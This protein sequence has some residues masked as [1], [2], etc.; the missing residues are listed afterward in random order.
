[1]RTRIVSFVL[2][3]VLA[4]S[5]VLSVAAQ[6]PTGARSLPASPFPGDGAVGS[7]PPKTGGLKPSAPTAT[8]L[9]GAADWLLTQQDAAGWFPW[10][11]GTGVTDNTQ[12]TTARGLLKAYLLTGTTGYRAAAV[13]NGDYLVPNYPRHFTDLDPRIV[14]HDALFL[15]EL[16][17][18]TG[19]AKYANFLQDY[20]WDKLTAGTY[21]EANNQDAA[22]WAA[23]VLSGRSGIV[24]LSPWD[25]SAPAIAAHIAGESAIRDAI[26]AEVKAGLE[27]TTAAD[28]EY[29][30]IGLA[31]AV[32]ASAVTGVALNPAA[33]VHSGLNTAGLATRLAGYQRSDG[34]WAS[35]TYASSTFD[36]TDSSTQTTAFAILALRAYNGTLYQSQVSAGMAFI[37]PG[38]QASSGQFLDYPGAA[39]TDAGGVE[40]HGEAISALV[41]T[42]PTQLGFSTANPVFCAPIVVYINLSSVTNLYGYQFKVGYD[43]TKVS[44]TGALVTSWFGDA[45]SPSGWTGT[46]SAGTCKFAATKSTV[47][48][49]PV[50][51]GGP[52]GQLTLTALAPGS[53]TLSF[54]EDILSDRDGTAIAHTTM[55]PLN[56]TVQ[57]QATVSGK[58]TLQGR[59]T[60]MTVG[61]VTL[62]ELG[63]HGFTPIEVPFSASTGDFTVGPIPLWPGG[64][65]YQLDAAH[66][67]YLGNRMTHLFAN[68]DAYVAPTTKLLGGDADNSGR[69]DMTDISCIAGAFGGGATPCGTSGSNDINNDSNVNILDLV[70]AAGNYDL[71]TPQP[72]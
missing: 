1:M 25:L 16:S 51:G 4:A 65:N 54:S 7:A 72:W 62:T 60:P 68:N 22:E 43:A 6:A 2:I 15:E 19:D 53:F 69:I 13:K 5:M 57:C 21:G 20:F 3:L 52:V 59:A 58:V 10:T 28:N 11:V 42:S 18:V 40:S 36:S 63:G 46:C 39:S 8:G 47:Y 50:N 44:A 30:I 70:L 35:G 37:L 48:P 64:S 41:G 32:W 55:S 27:A 45:Y 71:A 34:S 56:L 9:A 61:T 26:M 14:T 38:V 24:E 49:G 66:G 29:D 31:G 67:L 17:Q 33:G 12:G 23:S